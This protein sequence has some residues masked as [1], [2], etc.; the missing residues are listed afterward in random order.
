MGKTHTLLK[1]HYLPYKKAHP[2]HLTAFPIRRLL[3]RLLRLVARKIKQLPFAGEGQNIMRKHAGV[4]LFECLIYIALFSFIATASVSIVARLWQSGMK[5]ASI[6][7]SRLTLYS[8][9]DALARELK[10]APPPTKEWKLISSECLIWPI[11]ENKKDRCWGVK[12]GTLF[13]TEGVYNAQREVWSK[14]QSSS[15]APLT[16]LCFEISGTD[17]ITHIT[18]LLSDGI[19]TIQEKIA[20]HNR[21]LHA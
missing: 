14:K 6:E 18:V 3:L 13:R 15:I 19:T 10:S 1:T 17:Q 12:K 4:T 9:F 5:A 16:E 8:A 21:K 11:V 7:R 20:L 2:V